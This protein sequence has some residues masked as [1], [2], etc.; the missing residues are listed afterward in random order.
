[1][2]QSDGSKLVSAKEKQEKIRI[3]KVRLRVWRT[4]ISNAVSMYYLSKDFWGRDGFMCQLGRLLYPIIQ[5]SPRLGV[6][7]EGIV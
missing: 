7:Y 1:M 5:S 4:A 2:K 6:D 3:G